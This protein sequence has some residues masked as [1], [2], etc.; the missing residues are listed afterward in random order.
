MLKSN[1]N[2]V[3]DQNSY[4]NEINFVWHIF[5]TSSNR[6]FILIFSLKR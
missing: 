1:H 5:D 6:N 3:C 4:K 2:F